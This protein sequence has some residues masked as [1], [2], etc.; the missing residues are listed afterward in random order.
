LFLNEMLKFVQSL[1]MCEI[2]IRFASS[3]TKT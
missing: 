1:H 2:K 3:L